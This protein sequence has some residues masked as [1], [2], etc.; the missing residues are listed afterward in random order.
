MNRDSLSHLR[1]D[2]AR[3]SQWNIGYFSSGFVFWVYVA[4]T[5][6]LLPIATARFYWLA[7]TFLIFLC[8]VAISRL[9][10]ADPF[11]TGNA[12]G[13]LVGYT[14]MSVVTLT[15]PIVVVALIHPFA[16]WRQP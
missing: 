16:P 5:A 8:V 3:R 11:S 4:V 1:A 6:Y 12:L 7:G 2:L 13:E 10:R 14:H 9:L 15:L